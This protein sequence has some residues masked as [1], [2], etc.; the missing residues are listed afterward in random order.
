MSIKVVL[1]LVG[2]FLFLLSMRK[3]KSER[4][5]EVRKP[6]KQVVPDEKDGD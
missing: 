1:L 2:V 3:T 5:V 4:A 6:V